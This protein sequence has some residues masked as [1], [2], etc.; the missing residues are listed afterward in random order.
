MTAGP[1]CEGPLARPLREP[2]RSRALAL[3]RLEA[4]IALADHEDLAATADDLAVAMPLLGGLEGRQDFH[5][6]ASGRSNGMRK[7][8]NHKGFPGT[9]QKPRG[10]VG[11]VLRCPDHAR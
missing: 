5:W 6:I 10:G 2:R 4:R 11:K 3:A 8:R 1:K 9:V 7:T